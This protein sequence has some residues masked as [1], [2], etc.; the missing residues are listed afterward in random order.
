MET[1]TINC[2]KDNERVNTMLTF[3][4]RHFEDYRSCKQEYDEALPALTISVG[5]E[6]IKRL[7]EAIIK[8][9][10]VD[11]LF[12]ESLGYQ[13]NLDSFHNPGRP[14]F[15]HSDFEI[16]LRQECM[17]EIPAREEANQEIENITGSLLEKD[18]SSYNA[19]NEYLIYLE[20][21]VPKLSHY[22]GFNLANK[23]LPMTEPHYRVNRI[24]TLGY[25]SFINEW[26]EVDI[27][28]LN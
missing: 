28:T 5:E 18:P 13:A 16:Y 27:D 25:R 1:M 8:R 20:C 14:A 23:V 12:A 11:M 9:T 15:Y 19:I 17:E 2:K 10:A 6:N 26:F 3:L 7:K 22:F 24:L 21:A 4:E